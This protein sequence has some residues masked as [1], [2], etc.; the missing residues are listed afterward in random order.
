MLSLKKLRKPDKPD[1]EKQKELG[2]NYPNGSRYQSSSFGE[3]EVV[4]HVIQ[5][6][7][8]FLKLQSVAN[9]K[10]TAYLSVLQADPK[11]IRRS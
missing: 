1:F 11:N 5:N 10:N 7:E 2:L 3:A 8:R 6:G 4:A 9:P